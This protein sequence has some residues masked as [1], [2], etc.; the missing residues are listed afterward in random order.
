MKAIGKG[1]GWNFHTLR[2][3]TGTHLHKKGASPIAIKDQLR[4][5]DIRVTVNYYVGTDSDYQKKIV[6][7]LT[8]PIWQDARA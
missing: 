3:T 8:P 6:E 4:H 1:K 5:S 7:T 2:H